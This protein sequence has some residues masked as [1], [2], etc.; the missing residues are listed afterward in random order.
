MALSTPDV[1]GLLSLYIEKLDFYLISFNLVAFLQ[2]FL[3]KNK[4]D[5]SDKEILKGATM[6]IA[7]TQR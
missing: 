7:K 4:R 3:K 2:F 1:I 5:F 6:I